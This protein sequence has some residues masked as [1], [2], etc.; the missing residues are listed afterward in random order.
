MQAGKSVLTNYI[1]LDKKF[2]PGSAN[3]DNEENEDNEDIMKIM[4]I[5]VKM[6]MSLDKS[7]NSLKR[8]K[9]VI[10][11]GVTF[12]RWRC[13]TQNWTLLIKYSFCENE[14]L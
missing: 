6:K 2:C 11:C 10:A 9:V 1:S 4:K 12:R 14:L 3:E 7:E 13:L 5:M 8:E